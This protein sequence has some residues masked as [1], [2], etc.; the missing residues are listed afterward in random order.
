[1]P[2]IRPFKGLR[3][4]PE[5][6]GDMGSI[7]C[8]PYDIIPPA[9]QQELYDRSGYN[10][11]RLELPKEDDPYGAAAERIV[12]WMQNGIL[13]QDD[14]SALYPYYQ[15]YTDPEGNTYTRKGFFCALRLHEFSEKKVLPH[16]RTL[17]GPKKDRLNL[18]K[19]TQANISSI[20]GLYA[21]EKLQADKA[22]EEFAVTHD[23]E[24]DAVFQGVR[25]RL[26][27]MT[28]PDVI[29]TVQ[30]VLLDRQ[31]YIADGHHRYET[32]VNY[33]NL[34]SEENHSHTGD[35]PYNFILIYLANI[36]DEGLIIFPLHRM[37]HSLGRFS[38]EGLIDTLSTHFEVKPLGGR[39]ELRHYL[40]SE[41]SSHVYG[42]V[43]SEGI[44][45]IKMKDSPETLLGDSVPAPLLQ[46]SVV[47]L[48]E[49]IL[50]RVLGITPEAMR[51]QT[52]LV[53]EED[54]RQVFDAVAHG[55]I[56][57][58]FVVK[59]TTVQQVLDISGEG[60]VMPQKSTYFYPKIM[61]GL[62]MHR[63]M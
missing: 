38:P 30:Q 14:E 2:E 39:E 62:V 57:V 12:R 49:L 10:A 40:E 52:N 17:S 35:E 45:G 15:T 59:A 5:T 8:P 42:V 13:K 47:V 27:K 54:D 11:V 32:G 34:R 6:A 1:M 28:D 26:W 53:Y 4:D 41:S 23:P 20:F 60:E 24:V 21:D 55:G 56:Q 25:N 63:L 36:F 51:S 43:T 61:T 37:V 7:I 19:R 48:H 46:L 3:Y 58:G 44:W 31:V 33:R 29:A 9:M 16:E 50:H 22:I 18:F